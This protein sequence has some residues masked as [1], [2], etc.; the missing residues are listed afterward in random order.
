MVLKHQIPI[1]K[2]F[3]FE[4]EQMFISVLSLQIQYG[5]HSLKQISENSFG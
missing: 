2:N 1:L 3:A 5:S 4:Q